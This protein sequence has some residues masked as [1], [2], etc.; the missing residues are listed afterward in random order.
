MKNYQLSSLLFFILISFVA[1]AQEYQNETFQPTNHSFT[2]WYQ[3]MMKET[4]NIYHAQ[5]AYNNYFRNK[6]LEESKH[7][8]I[9]RRWIEDAKLSIDADGNHIKN[10]Y[11]PSEFLKPKN[12]T[13]TTRSGTWQSIGPNFA[14]KTKCNTSSDLSGG[15]CDRVY[16][17]PYN[18]NNLFA[19]FSYGGLWVS[20][21]QG[22]TWELT[23][24]D[25]P[26]GTNTYANRDIYYGEIEASPLDADLIYAATEYGL[27][28]S[29]NAGQ[30][31]NICPE[32]NRDDSGDT[33]SYYISLSKQ[34]Q[35][36]VLSTFGRKVYRS[37][38][39]GQ[40][41]TVVFDNSNG[42]P[43]HQFTN[44][45]SNNSN[46]GIYERTYNFF[47][48]ER[49]KD[50]TGVFYLGVYNA[51]NKPEIYKSTDDGLTFNLLVNLDNSLGRTL[52]SNLVLKASQEQ[53][54]NF[55]IHS[56]FT[57]DSLYQYTSTGDLV[58]RDDINAKVFTSG[59]L[60]DKLEAF[61]IDPF[62]ESTM[63]GGFY[64][65]SAITKSVNGGASFI[66]QTS[67]Y[68]G[69]PK[70]VHPDVRAIDCQGDLVF[71]GSDGGI[72]ISKNGMTSV[73]S[74]IGREISSIDLWGFS[75]SP[76]SDLVVVGC[77][78]GP[79]KI[80][81]SDGEN[82]WYSI[83]GGDASD[84]SIN[85][86]NE[87]HIVFD[88]A[89]NY[90]FAA[91]LD[92][93]NNIQTEYD[94]NNDI[95]LNQI[96]YHPFLYPIAYAKQ[97][98][99]LKKITSATFSASS[100]SDQYT[101]QSDIDVVRIAPD[102]PN[103]IYALLNNS[104]I[105]KSSDGGVTFV[106]ITPPTSVTNNQTNISDLIVG[107]TKNEIYAAYA[108]WQND[109]KILISNDGGSVWENITTS[110]LPV[111]P[112]SRVVYQP[113]TAQGIY[114]VTAGGGGIWYKNNSMTTWEELGTGLPTM[115]YVRNAF[116]V[117]N[118]NKIRVGGSRGVWE[119]DLF[120][121]S[122]P[123]ANF[124]IEKNNW[125]CGNE[126]SFIQ[127]STYTSTEVTH[128]WFFEGGTPQTTNNP[129]PQITYFDS[130][131]FDVTLTVTDANGNSNTQTLEDFIQ[132]AEGANCMQVNIE[133][134][135]F[136][137]LQVY[138]NP[139]TKM[140]YIELPNAEK[141]IQ[142]QLIDASGKV[143]L[144]KTF[145]NQ[146]MLNINIEKF[147]AGIYFLKINAEGDSKEVKIVKE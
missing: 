27:L 73:S 134:T 45:Y 53:S 88:R 99:V 140:I 9:F 82:G 16:I 11:H 63:Y 19:G 42:G 118:K 83:G 29:T 76:I 132:V 110:D 124:A 114:L 93:N 133:E 8:N 130:G 7:R 43:N 18:L 87:K 41:W 111:T 10:P 119:H 122:N 71:I 126:V 66:D 141:I 40:S 57:F 115:G 91:K 144:D 106:E 48:L 143:V 56:L 120:E 113:G 85:S 89:I 38:N 92:N 100:I 28:K 81:R 4:P 125:A 74:D 50:E 5:E 49:A 142:T 137:G 139:A 78:H 51:Q 69:C 105:F 64:F 6:P 127:N 135:T 84:A 79:T 75:S 108:N 94:I 59:T 44:Q 104:T 129:S 17:N 26:N 25:I 102:D 46:F 121:S 67:G 15:F 13:A 2:D 70:Y 138:P 52:P 136:E 101:F 117:P 47:G 24:S 60:V 95:D 3:E 22:D 58:S 34:N 31:W 12:Q 131:N 107:A 33:R 146:Q 90:Q 36:I 68:S 62:N 54:N 80:R 97:D 72:A 77:D 30:E 112:I 103:H 21:D 116:V 55:F 1:N 145:D 128:E 14:E 147:A 35:D 20:Q 98:N 37:T 23:D 32:L 39:G 65:A 123:V 96:A 61:A 109:T 86:S